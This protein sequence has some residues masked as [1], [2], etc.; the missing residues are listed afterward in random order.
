MKSAFNGLLSRLDINK[1]GIPKF[2]GMLKE[3]F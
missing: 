3:I 1:E 2:E